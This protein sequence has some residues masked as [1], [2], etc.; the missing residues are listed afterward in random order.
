MDWGKA[1][2]RAIAGFAG[3]LML[4]FAGG[5]CQSENS[6][7]AP[8]ALAAIPGSFSNADWGIV[9]SSV[10]TP[11]GYVEWDLLRS[12][13]DDVRARLM[14]YIGLI[15]AVSPANHAE[16]FA[17]ANDRLAYW[18]NAYNAMCVYAVVEHNYP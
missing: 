8:T 9:L 17:S 11:D 15:N 6:Y 12:N 16:L 18:I 2:V 4:I 14:A 1:I 10:V 3:V 13:A 5:G 7:T